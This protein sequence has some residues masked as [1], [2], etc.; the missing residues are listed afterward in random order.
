M[1]IFEVTERNKFFSKKQ[2]KGA[3]Y[4]EVQLSKL[5]PIN[6]NTFE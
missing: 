3:L 1:V 6:Q 2:N 4:Y 5:L